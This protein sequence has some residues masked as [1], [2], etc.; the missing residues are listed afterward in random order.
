MG[1]TVDT[2]D[3]RRLAAAFDQAAKVAPEETRKVVQRG[4]LNIKKDA[5]RR[6][7]GHPHL[8]HLPAAITYDSVQTGRGATAEIGPDKTRR[9]G[10]LGHLPEYGSVNNPPMPYLAPALQAEEPRFVQ[11]L[12]DAALK[13]IGL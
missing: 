6:I 12:E 3:A 11:A 5:Q 1:I 10:P 9:Q 2:S 13:G 8:R 4:A 7:S